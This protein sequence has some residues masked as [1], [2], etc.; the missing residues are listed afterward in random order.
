MLSKTD[1]KIIS[2]LILCGL[3]SF[4]IRDNNDENHKAI[5][6]HKNRGIIL[7]LSFTINSL[8][9]INEQMSKFMLTVVILNRDRHLKLFIQED[10]KS[11]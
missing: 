1:V 3:L 7:V 4:K 9:K 10:S 11:I 6:M 8:C 2:P 5:F